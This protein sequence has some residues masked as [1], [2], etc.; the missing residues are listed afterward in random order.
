MK[1]KFLLEL[2]WRGLIK[3]ITPYTQSHFNENEI[4]AGYVGFDPTADSLHVGNLCAINLLRHLQLAGLKPL[5][6]LGGFT[7]GIGDPAGKVSERKV[8]GGD[9]VAHNLNMLKLQFHKFLD[10]DCGDNSAEFVDNNMWLQ[11]LSLSDFLLE[12]GRYFTVNYMTSKDSVKQRLKNGLSFTEFTY[13]LFQAYD[14]YWLYSNKNCKLQMGGSDQWGNITGGCELIKKRL[15]TEAFALTT[16]LLTKSDGGKFGKSE[17][18]NIWLDPNLTSPYKFYQFWLNVED[19]QVGKLLRIF[20]FLSREEIESLEKE[21]SDNPNALKRVLADTVT[22]QVHSPEVLFQVKRAS[23]L[24]FGHSTIQDFEMTD[25]I[26]L[27]DVFSS[28]PRINIT[29]SEYKSA[30]VEYAISKSFNISKSESRRLI[31]GNGISINKEK[32]KEYDI[33]AYKYPLLKGKYLLIQKGKSFSIIEVSDE[34]LSYPS[35]LSEKYEFFNN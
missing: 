35:T 10:F 19:S 31:N 9:I 17:E 33:P 1:S 15:R 23:N 27:Q 25:D 22:A 6:L 34:L 16:D 11:R 32:I 3:D 12:A 18:G 5:V 30:N 14:F 20:T 4:F 8:L 7:G 21:H 24:L 29:N 28:I 13:Q 26:L 2:E